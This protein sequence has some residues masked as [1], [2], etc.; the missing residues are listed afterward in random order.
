MFRR[1]QKS[2]EGVAATEFALIAP[3]LVALLL[4][5][6]DYCLYM[7]T[8]IRLEL[9]TRAAAQYM[10]N[11]GDPDNIVNDVVIPSSLGVDVST[12]DDVVVRQ[13]VI[14]RCNDGTELSCDETCG[15]GDYERHFVEV[16]LTV[17]YTAPFLPYVGLSTSMPL[18]AYVALQSQ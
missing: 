13:D 18:Q 16:E 8:Q 12:A 9:A 15:A 4:G 5:T 2:S 1:F 7:N 3:V 14:C 10:L 17:N 11:G 6:I